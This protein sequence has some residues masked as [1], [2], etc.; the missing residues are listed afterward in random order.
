MRSLI[1]TDT[2]YES[3]KNGAISRAVVGGAIAG[4]S[5]AVIGAMTAKDQVSEKKG[6]YLITIYL[7]DIDIP[8]ITLNLRSV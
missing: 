5:G 4:G 3:K 7:N 8:Q 2:K 1:T 6:N